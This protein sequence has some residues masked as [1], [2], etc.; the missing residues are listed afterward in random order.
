MALNRILI[1][2]FSAWSWPSIPGLRKFRGHKVHSANWD[3][4]FDYSNKKIAVIG[5]GSSG[6]QILPQMAK[7][8]GTQVTSF[9]RAPT[10]VVSTMNP[11]SLLGNDGPA[12][13][14][15][16]TD[17][18]RRLFRDEPQR[19]HK[20]RKTIIHKINDSFKMVCY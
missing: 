14:P 10:Y 17:E 12:Y 11:G 16:Y 2:V 3:H 8:Q 9:Q 7:L 6:I 15:E 5:N 18:E 20:Y 19:H 4:D 1:R 13:N